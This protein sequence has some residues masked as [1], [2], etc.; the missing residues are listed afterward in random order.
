MSSRKYVQSNET[1]IEGCV[2]RYPVLH[3]TSVKR[4]MWSGAYGLRST[5]HWQSVR[6]ATAG[7][8]FRVLTINLL[9]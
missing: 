8:E 1:C 2:K 4:K 5:I 6:S 7:L 9:I 3:G